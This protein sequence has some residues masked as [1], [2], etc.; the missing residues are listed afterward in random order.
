MNLFDFDM[1]NP[2]KDALHLLEVH[3]V[4]VFVRSMT[5]P[6]YLFNFYIKGQ[7][8]LPIFNANPIIQL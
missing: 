2:K 6:I 4:M 1:F 7:H 5:F 3:D 8:L